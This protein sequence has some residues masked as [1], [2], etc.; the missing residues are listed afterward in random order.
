MVRRRAPVALLLLAAGLA[1]CG[2]PAP[3]DNTLTE[4]DNDLIDTAAREARQ[5]TAESPAGAAPPP[6]ARLSLGRDCHAGGRSGDCSA[7]EIVTAPHCDKQ[8]TTGL[9]WATRLPAGI[10]LY[11][12]A[13]VIEAAGSDAGDC[14]VRIVSYVADAA[15]RD[16][17][18]WYRAAASAAGYAPQVS[19]KGR[20]QFVAGLRSPAGDAFHVTIAADADTG[21]TVDLIVN[22]GG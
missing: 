6:A 16:V 15:P 19:Q 11:P 1:G 12:G 17:A 21:S 4:L 8:F 20:E 10:E 7:A 5:A 9:R 3:A 22:H 2:K 14:H 13:K 18:E